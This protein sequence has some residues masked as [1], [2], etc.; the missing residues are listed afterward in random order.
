MPIVYVHGVANRRGHGYEEDLASLTRMLANYVAPVISDDPDGVIVIDSYWGDLG[1][2]FAWDRASRPVS[3]LLGMGAEH[4]PDDIRLQTY[5]HLHDQLAPIPVEQDEP[6]PETGGLI[7]AGAVA[8]P[9]ASPTLSELTPTQLSDFVTAI[10][11]SVAGPNDDVDGAVITADHLAWD[12][13]FRAELTSLPSDEQYRRFAGAVEA[14]LQAQS[15][16]IGQGIGW[17]DRVA[18]RLGEV[19]D[20]GTKAPAWAASRVLLEARR[21]LNDSATVF[22]GDIF[23]YLEDRG[24]SDAPGRIEGRVLSRLREAKRLSDQRDGEPIVVLSHSMG[25]Q[26]VYD[27]VSEFLP[28]TDNGEEPIHIDFWC[29]AASQVGLFEELK[30]FHNSSDDYSKSR[31]NKAPFPGAN[32]GAWWNVWDSN[33][34]LSF[35]AAEIFDGVDDQEYSSGISVIGAHSGYFQRPS[36]FRAFA[37]KLQATLTGG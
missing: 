10:I 29:A 16:L 19:L 33:D 24:D 32:L 17:L 1:A 2:D 7:A 27:I 36:F 12:P 35:S 15:G 25:G 37:A 28:N 20:R 13:A 5:A 14:D 3:P 9:G 22:L 18:D 11:G 6:G 31:G 4:T 8:P 26:I 30:L 23:R 34:V 21:P